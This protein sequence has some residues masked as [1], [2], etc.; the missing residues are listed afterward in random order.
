MNRRLFRSRTDSVLSG[1]C[2]GLGLY[3]QIDPGLVRIFFVLLALGNGLGVLIYILLW[4]VVPREDFARD[5]TLADTA[6]AA[7]NEIADQARSVGEEVRQ[8]VHNPNPRTGLYIGAGLI[9]L[10]VFTLIQNL[11]LPWL[12]WLN[13]SV[14]WPVL[15]IVAGIALLTRWRR[16]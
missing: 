16:E 9:L 15:L 3:L 11:D 10:G 5:V 12:H 1:V 6:R 4:I 2:G 7:A 8:A 14:L 13:F